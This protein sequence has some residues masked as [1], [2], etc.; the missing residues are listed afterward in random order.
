MIEHNGKQ[1][2]RVTEI[3]A[4]DE[5]DHIDSGVLERAQIRGTQIHNAIADELWGSL[6]LYDPAYT[7]YMQSWRRW[8]ERSNIDSIVLTESRLYD[9][10]LMI[11]GQI[12]LLAQC[13]DKVILYDWKTSVNPSQ[14]WEYQAT[15]YI[16]LLRVNGFS[17]IDTAYFLRLK[18]DGTDP[19]LSIYPYNSSTMDI[20]RDMVRRFWDE[21]KKKEKELR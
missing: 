5:Y 21:E 2:A 11:T 12:D 13:G 3:I 8:H 9:D 16:Y 17:V 19:K 10:E 4:S 7:G 15:M 18:K 14:A 1:Y 20:C 6:A